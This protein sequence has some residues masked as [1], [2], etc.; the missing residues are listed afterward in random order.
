VLSGVLSSAP[1]L[2]NAE[3]RLQLSL[4]KGVRSTVT[5]CSLPKQLPAPI[6]ERM[7]EIF[8][9]RSRREH[10]KIIFRSEGVRNWT[11]STHS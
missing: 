6:I 9:E 8:G 5:A 1:Y 4:V 3:L 11:Q 7:I 10:I 2:D